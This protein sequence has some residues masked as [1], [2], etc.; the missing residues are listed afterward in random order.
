MAF[1]GPFQ[2]KLLYDS[3]IELQIFSPVSLSNTVLSY[4]GIYEVNFL[5]MRT[6]I[7]ISQIM[8]CQMSLI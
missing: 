7:D 5:S 3:M 1:K 2:P 8:I 6:D 4:S